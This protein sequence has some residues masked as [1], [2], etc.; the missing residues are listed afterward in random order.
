[1]GLSLRCP[2]MQMF[3]SYFMQA[4][5]S[6]GSCVLLQLYVIHASLSDRTV[7]C[8]YALMQNKT[9][10]AY[11]EVLTAVKQRCSEIGLQPGPSIVMTDF[12]AAAMNSTRNVFADVGVDIRGCFFHLTQATWRKLQELGLASRIETTSVSATYAGCWMA[13][14]LFR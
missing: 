10:Q 12:E 13:L 4:Y 1:M 3:A 11:Y 6:F 7:P 14:R 9:Q 8:V 5:R 2:N